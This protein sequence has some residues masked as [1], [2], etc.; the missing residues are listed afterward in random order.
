[1]DVELWLRPWARYVPACRLALASGSAALPDDHAGPPWLYLR[2]PAD[3]PPLVD[4]RYDTAELSAQMAERAAA[5][6]AQHETRTS[7][8]L[9]PLPLRR[10]AGQVVAVDGGTCRL[11]WPNA[12]EKPQTGVEPRDD[13]ERRSAA[14]M[15]RAEAVWDRIGDVE[16]ALSDPA[17]LWGRLRERWTAT[18]AGEPRMDEIVRQ[19]R[20]MGRVLDA[21]E[22]HLRRILRRVHRM[23]PLGRVQELDRRSLLWI[24]RQPGE[25][26]AERAG[27]SQRILAIAREESF[28]TLENRVLRAYCELADRHGRD[29][30][31]RN[32]TRRQTRRARLVE[33]FGKRCRRLAHELAARG[34][35]QAEPGLTPNFVLQQNPLYHR[36]WDAWQALLARERAT[37]ELWRWQA[38]SW[39]EFCA[40]ALVVALMGVAGARLV[41]TAPLWFRDEQRRGTW[42][43]TDS[44]LAVVHLPDRGLIAEV[45]TVARTDALAGFAAPLWLR[46]GRAGETRGFLRR[47]AV[48][49]LWSPQGG[50]AAG[51][52]AEVRQL[53][54]QAGGGALAGGLVLRPAVVHEHADWEQD[55]PALTLT[56]GT[57][58]AALRDALF[59]VTE[60]VEG[61]LPEDRP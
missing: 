4:G 44:P 41:A 60:F 16:D 27:D 40:L 31:G 30:I 18:D 25:R 61:F 33:H 1:M 54:V 8:W 45:Q 12:P 37:D 14:L 39:E 24:A 57:E 53:L 49:P 21:L 38:R 20:E 6:Q 17:R 58:G 48:W 56:L 11:I 22:A 10:A 36:V 3:S 28:D 19:A 42:I 47:L 2:Q 51:E 9:L 5:G 26:L 50:L 13:R 59:M 55:G 29:Y 15:L 35:R 23:T 43:E 7:L 46:I 34:V 32:R 52:A